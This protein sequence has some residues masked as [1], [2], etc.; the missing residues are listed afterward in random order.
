MAEESRYLTTEERKT[1]E[2][3]PVRLAIHVTL[4]VALLTFAAAI[5]LYMEYHMFRST[6]GVDFEHYYAAAQMVRRGAASQ[7]YEPAVQY[8]FQVRYS[9]SWG[10]LFNYPAVAV[11]LYWPTAY[12]TLNHA[13]LLWASICLAVTI[14]CILLIGHTFRISKDVCFPPLVAMLFLPLHSAQRAGQTDAFVL[15]AYVLA[16]VALKSE[17]PVLAGVALALGLVKFNLVLPF[18]FIMLL[19]RQWRF[20]S[21]FAVGSV[22]MVAASV[23][24][25]GRSLF[26]AYP[27]LLLT[28]QS[29]PK[30]GFYPRWMPNVRG[31][32][33]LIAG[34]E[35]PFWIAIVVGLPMCIWIARRWV[36][37]ETGFSAALTIT[38]LTTYHS[39]PHD[40]LLLLIPIT[41]AA[42]VLPR[43]VPTAVVFALL[44]LLPYICI[45][46]NCFALLCAPM[47]LLTWL[48]VRRPSGEYDVSVRDDYSPSGT[49]T[50]VTGDAHVKTPPLI[51]YEG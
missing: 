49:R 4:R 31:L 25:A 46:R 11:L 51:Q 37:L 43:D 45:D 32:F 27:K 41:L 24:V 30:G 1:E 38:L 21:G 13:Y 12:F 3:K 6:P 50:N 22:L 29:L 8:R 23:A 42:N 35:P 36:T 48:L 14:G 47:F 7:L 26:T 2:K 10:P 39:Y 16:L 15:L 33:F 40:L 18:V 17:R 44:A 20:V 9:R 34:H 19:R 5:C 28:M